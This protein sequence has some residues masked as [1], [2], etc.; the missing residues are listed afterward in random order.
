MEQTIEDIQ[1][2]I[3]NELHELE[4]VISTQAQSKS[5]LANSVINHL[6]KAHSKRIRPTIV[7][8]SALA[9]GLIQDSTD[10]IELA[11]IIEYLHTASLLH[12]DVIDHAKKEEAEIQHIRFGV[13]Q[14]AYY[15]AIFYMQKHSK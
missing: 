15:Q 12:D 4:V 10:H 6:L 11:C 2:L 1:Q 3:A 7:I 5:E 8:L 13:T 9:T 14:Q